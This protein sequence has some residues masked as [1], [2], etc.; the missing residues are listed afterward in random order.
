MS[1]TVEDSSGQPFSR[2][3]SDEDIFKETK[4]D[5]T[6]SL[7]KSAMSNPADKEI[8]LN[9]DE[10][11]SVSQPIA[12]TTAGG[13]EPLNQAGSEGYIKISVA[14]PKKVGDG[15][16]SYLVYRVVTRTNIRFFSK[17]EMVVTRRFSDF[18]GLHT[19]L[20]EKYLH[21][22]RIVPPAPD[23]NLVGTTKLVISQ[24]VTGEANTAD[25]VEK[26]RWALERYLNR[27]ASHPILQADPDFREFLELE[28]E[29]PRATNTSAI[30]GA[31]VLR[32][33][34]RVGETVNKMTFKMEEADSWFE[35]KTQQIEALDAQLRRLQ[36]STEALALQRK[37][38]AQTTST[39]AKSAALLSTCEEHENFAKALVQLSELEE[40]IQ[41]IH[42]EQ[43]HADFFLLCEFLKDYIGLIGAVKDTF[44]ERVKAY[45][46]WQHAQG[47]LVK[48]RESAEKLDSAGRTER[49]GSARD[50]VLEWE[51][52][53]ERA[54]EEFEA[55]SRTIKQEFDRFELS[56]IKDF[57]HAF[58]SY[59]E[60]LLES[61]QK[62]VKQ[63][64][65]YAIQ[66]KQIE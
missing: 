19:K 7:F 47:M 22:G 1:E 37:E 17:Q 33:F 51:V 44:H 20:M 36:S 26:R 45:Q 32:L 50:D 48:K 6:S 29:L 65:D 58:I 13:Q 3:E 11:P 46:T 63:W 31:G 10:S 52:K 39:F 49:A 21:K 55:I 57:K 12:P 2:V 62:L 53:V 59:L 64:E 23:K 5:L 28:S 43:V 66:V 42:M 4:E 27:T 54:R 9:D 24:Q 16:S 18:L 30:S 14:E 34:N 8:D 61:Q 35:E 25:F 38:L 56:R 15:M 40:K 60:A 41:G